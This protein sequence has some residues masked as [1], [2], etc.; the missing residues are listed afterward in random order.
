MRC[1]I[2]VVWD[3]S[4]GVLTHHVLAP[5]VVPTP[6][7]ML[8]VEM[9]CTQMWTLG[10]LLGQNKLTTTVLHKSVPIV[11]DGHDCGT[12]IPDITPPIMAN[13]Y[14]LISWPFSSRK[15]AFASSSVE[16]NGKPTACA[17][18]G[19]PP[20]PM[21]T[22]GDPVSA[23]TSLVLSNQLNTVS[24]HISLFDLF[25]GL[26]GILISM[27]IDFV[28]EMVSFNRA[29]ASGVMSSIFGKQVIS[30]QAMEQVAATAI[31]SVGR[32]LALDFAKKLVP[33]DGKDVA[34]RVATAL[35]GLL[36]STLQ[37]NPTF[38]LGVGGP[39]L[40]VKGSV[41]AAPAP[42]AA[43]PNPSRFSGE[44]QVGGQIRDTRGGGSSW[45]QPL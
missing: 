10:F 26:L 37:G 28:F 4:V 35:G 15:I 31:R 9:I 33:L 23:P 30:R 2:N 36:T 45:G 39:G 22:C 43:D 38:E 6:A 19:L 12:M 3:V 20:L 13:L 44:G 24:V 40:N 16:M 1:T 18:I 34:K 41:G 42:T 21:M 29:G 14:Y 25:M 11:L 7:P 5:P 8:S 32:T 27:V 17:Q